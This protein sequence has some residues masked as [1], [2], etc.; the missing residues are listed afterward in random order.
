VRFVLNDPTGRFPQSS[1]QLFI[2]RPLNVSGSTTF[3]TVAADEFGTEG[4]TVELED[5]QRYR[6]EIKNDQGDS[7]TLGSYTTAINE[8]GNP[9]IFFEFSD[10]AEETSTLELTIYE[11]NNESN[12]L[13]GYPVTYSDLGNVTIDEALTDAQSDKEWVV[14]WEA[15]RNGSEISGS[16]LVVSK[17][18][19]DLPLSNVWLSIIYSAGI[20]A[21]A[22]L[23]GAGIGPAP[24]LIT[25][26]MSAGFAVF[27]GLAPPSIGFS[28]AILVIAIGGIYTVQSANKV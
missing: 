5:D 1:T 9:S 26:G 19:L 17:S 20:I 10:P 25:V 4:Y 11:R 23:V 8:T 3:Q 13:A 6:L 15:T 22:F 27:I 12:V 14:E 21:L 16:R 7:Q 18:L 28:V 24:A 2:K